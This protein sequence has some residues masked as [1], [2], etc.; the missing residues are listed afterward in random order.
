MKL[1]GVLGGTSWPSTI[2]PYRMLNQEAERRLGPGHSARIA[3]YSIDYHA[4]L[5]AYRTDRDAI[6]ALLRPE[7]DT[8]LSFRPDCWMIACNT[9]HATYDRLAQGLAHAPPFFHAVELVRRELLARSV[10]KVLLLGTRFTMEDGYFADPL[11]QVGIA[12]QIPALAERE[13]IDTIQ[14]RLA[15]GELDPEFATHFRDLIAHHATQGCEAVILGCT[16]LP[17][18]ITQDIC[19]ILAL[20]PLALQCRACV[21]FAVAS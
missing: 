15:A 10:G 13:R 18:V 1:I 12:V 2:L 9:L 21:D 5:A 20:D 8:L 19:P 3:L 11:R 16:E 7:I 17:L 6:P 4:I 14:P